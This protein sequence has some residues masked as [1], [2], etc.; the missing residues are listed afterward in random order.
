[1]KKIGH[2][3]M[4]ARF[5]AAFLLISSDVFRAMELHQF[6]AIGWKGFLVA[7]AIVAAGSLICWI[8]DSFSIS[9]RRIGN[10]FSIIIRRKGENEL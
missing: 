3:L 6:H 4:T 7:A 2:M 10:T 8:G 5:L 9:A 1:M